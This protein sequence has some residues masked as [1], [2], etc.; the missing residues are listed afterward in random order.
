[1]TAEVIQLNA[2]TKP[3][4]VEGKVIGFL[5]EAPPDEKVE[6]IEASG[7]ARDDFASPKIGV[8]WSMICRLAVRRFE[9]TADTVVSH[10]RR[11]GLLGDSDLR[12]LSGL[13]E[14]NLLTKTQALQVAEDIR[15]LARSRAVRVALMNEVELI[16]RGRFTPART[17][18]ALESIVHG[19]ATDFSVDESAENEL[20]ALNAAWEANAKAG[21]AN[22]D[23][24]GLRVLDEIIGGFPENLTF[25]HG[26]PG[27]GKNI[28]AS[29]IIRAQLERD[30]E[31]EEPT[32]TGL[33]WLEDGTSALLRRWQAEDL[34]IPLR[35]VGWKPL[36]EEQWA[37]KGRI[38]TRV[39]ELLRRII[40]YKHDSISR[41]E[42][43]R[44]AMRMIFRDKVRR[45]FVDNMKE[46]DHSDPRRFKEGW[47]QVAETTRVMRNLSRDTGVPIVMLV[48]DTEDNEKGEGKAR[49]PDPRKMTGGQ[50]GGDRARL[51][52]GAWAD[53]PSLF[54]T[55]TKGNEISE[56]GLHGPTVE[57]Q[58]NFSAG[59]VNPEGGRRVDI[60]AREAE[61]RREAKKRANQEQA[62]N[63]I[64]RQEI[65][66]RIKADKA[67]SEPTTE[68]KKEEPQAQLSLEEP[69]K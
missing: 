43:R 65:A 39:F 48:H 40:H 29:S 15:V 62:L 59:T 42:L 5:L 64:E 10:G 13:Q 34:G 17:A 66:K 23:P 67:A 11:V 21:K 24:T 14:G 51:V 25:I 47:Q 6:V 35:E 45:I 20:L 7:L 16:D 36:T 1:M 8:V 18:A 28:I 4:E 37:Q 3:D 30:R 31:D 50:A 27:V 68:P 53:G 22:L 54:I 61:A 63:T 12:W 58:R 60:R 33:F 44:R 26:K 49:P 38:D 19:L 52:L 46:I 9:I 55:V 41:A 2:G 56:A 69:K 57:L 32:K